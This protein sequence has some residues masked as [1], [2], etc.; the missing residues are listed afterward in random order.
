[1]S[2]FTNLG[3]RG[4]VWRSCLPASDVSLAGLQKGAPTPLPDAHFEMLRFSN[5]GEGD[6]GVEPG[7]FCP[8]PA[9][10]VLELNQSYQVSDSI[11]WF[12][13][14]GSNG[15]DELF[16]FDLRE[17]PPWRVVMAPFIEIEV[18]TV[19]R[20]SDNFDEFLR[21]IGVRID[22]IDV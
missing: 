5:G 1:M 4:G 21:H 14:F 7:W 12:F 3:D 8:W 17:G 18:S 22:A 10:Q 19:I 9:D 2:V 13:G 6:L 11:P 16:A 20:V 15:G